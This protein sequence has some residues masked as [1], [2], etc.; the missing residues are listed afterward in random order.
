MLIILEILTRQKKVYEKAEEFSKQE[1]ESGISSE[2]I[3]TRANMPGKLRLIIL[4]T[5][6]H[7]YSKRKLQRMRSFGIPEQ[8][9]YVTNCGRA[10]TN[11]HSNGMQ[12]DL[13][14]SNTRSKSKKHTCPDQKSVHKRPSGQLKLS[15][16]LE[17]AIF[18]LMERKTFQ[19]FH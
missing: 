3:K 11:L 13:S 10:H 5:Y 12:F 17:K 15:I 19:V 4:N 8:A 16:K 1:I 18:I 6:R 7:I 2:L 9:I 14:N